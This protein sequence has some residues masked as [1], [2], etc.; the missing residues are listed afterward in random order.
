MPYPARIKSMFEDNYAFPM[1]SKRFREY[2]NICLLGEWSSRCIH[3]LL[4]R[5]ASAKLNM[6]D[7]GEEA[8]VDRIGICTFKR[9]KS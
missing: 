6:T 1:E 2:P 9:E 8:V 7:E 4:R 3:N 5:T